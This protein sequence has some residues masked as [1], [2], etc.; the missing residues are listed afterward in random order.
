MLIIWVG[1]LGRAVIDK[2]LASHG[3]ASAVA[4]WGQIGSIVELFSGV[5]LSGIGVGV[6]V[7]VAKQRQRSEQWA[8]LRAGVGLGL[9]FSGLLWIGVWLLF[10][11]AGLFCGLVDDRTGDAQLLLAGETIP[12]MDVGL[13]RG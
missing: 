9:F 5:G 12:I 2:V 6:S 8:T 1:L 4:L 10:I 13:G 7:L 3:G 11:V